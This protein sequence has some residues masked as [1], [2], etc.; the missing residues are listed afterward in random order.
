[1]GNGA[2]DSQH[3]TGVVCTPLHSRPPLQERDFCILK[4]HML[5]TIHCI[6]LYNTVYIFLLGGLIINNV[7]ELKI[8]HLFLGLLA[9][10]GIREVN[11]KPMSNIQFILIMLV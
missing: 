3:G 1:V 11:W 7:K 10:L 2:V 5:I 6:L 8:L 9:W 4:P